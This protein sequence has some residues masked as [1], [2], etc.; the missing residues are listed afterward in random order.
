MKRELGSFERALVITDQYAPFRSVYVLR[1]ESPPTPQI[2][3]QVLKSLQNHHPFLRAR[4]LQENG[5]YYFASLA[6]PA[7]PLQ[8]LPRWNNDHWLKIVEVQLDTC[9]ELAADPMFRCLYV[10]DANQKY[11][12]IIL[13]FFHPMLDAVS[14]EYLMNELLTACASYMDQKTV[15][16][17]EPAPP[18][19]ARFPSAYRGARMMLHTMGYVIR[20]TIEEAVY[21]LQTRGKPAPSLHKK[22]THGHIASL[23][24]PDSFIATLTRRAEMERVTLNAVLNA[25]LMIAVNR[26]LYAGKNVPMRTISFW[27][28]R[29]SVE[30]P[31]KN[32]NLACYMTPLRHSVPVEGGVNIWQLAHSLQKKFYYSLK[33]GDQ[34]VSANMTESLM[35]MTTGMR[36]FRLSS[37]ALNFVGD[38]QVKPEYGEII[39]NDLHGY[40]SAIDLGPEFSGQARLFNGHLIWDFTYLDADMNADEAKAIAEEIKSILNSAV[41]SPLFR[42]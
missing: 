35:K 41:T 39:V 42:I 24:L 9:I 18:L 13:N 3:G 7:L 21:R 20:Q 14:A 30:P 4:Y 25:A 10:Y 1:L 32:E 37:T 28:L 38:S 8:V 23:T 33:S 29:S 11:A 26:H 22:P 40:I 16:V 2:L 31:L 5:K 17:Y 15:T 12:E 34:F 6:D 27:D 36:S 19:E